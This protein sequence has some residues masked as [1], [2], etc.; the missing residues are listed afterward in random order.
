M[1][2][3]AW[4]PG[5][6]DFLHTVTFNYPEDPDVTK[7]EGYRAFFFDVDEVL[8]CSYCRDSFRHF[9][10]RHPVEPHLGDRYAL[11]RWLYRMHNLVNKKLKVPKSKVPSLLEVVIKYEARRSESEETHPERYFSEHTVT[12]GG[13]ELLRLLIDQE[14]QKLRKRVGGSGGVPLHHRSSSAAF[15]SSSSSSS[16]SSSSPASLLL[17]ANSDDQ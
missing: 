9:I 11:V 17:S 5:A 15:S 2:V 8:P 10:K 13:S 1:N 7:R 4:G 14:R 3:K 12:A 6:W 16:Y